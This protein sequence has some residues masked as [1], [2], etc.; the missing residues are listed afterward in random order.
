MKQNPFGAIVSV[1][2]KRRKVV[3]FF[4]IVLV[5]FGVTTYDTMTKSILPEA[6]FPY[7]SVATSLVGASAADMEEMVTIP[8]ENNLKQLKDVKKITSASHNGFA[9]VVIQFN[10]GVDNAIKVQQVQ[11]V[12][13][14]LRSKLPKDL[15]APVVEAYDIAKFPIIAVEIDGDR[16]YPQLKKN[17][18]TLER[19]LKAIPGVTTLE[20]DGLNK[21]YIKVTPNLEA[22][23]TYGLDYSLLSGLLKEHQFNM[24]LG[25]KTLYGM[26]YYF[27]S[28]NKMTSI[29]GLKDI[30]INLTR[31]QQIT[32]GDIAEV[33]MGEVTDQRGSYRLEKGHKQKIVRLFLYKDS[34]ADTVAINR[35]VKEL[36]EAFKAEDLQNTGIRTSMDASVFIQ[37]SINDVINNALGGLLS[38]IAVLFL[39]IHFREAIIAAMVI[40]I[41]MIGAFVLFK[42]FNLTLNIMSIMGL[43]I[44]LGMLVDNAIVVI[45]MI[46]EN[47]TH[48]RH[49]S[50][51]DII[52]KATN[53]VAPAIFSSTVTTVGAFIPLAFLSGGDGALIRA[54]PIATALAMGISFIVSITVTP[55]FAYGLI[56]R[57]DK[58]PSKW[59]MAWHTLLIGIIGAYA[60]SDNWQWTTASY[61][62]GAVFM[63]ATVLKYRLASREGQGLSWYRVL[64]DKVLH[65]R[66]YQGIVLGVMVL[67]LVYA[68][69]LLL[70]NRIPKEAMPKADSK[71]LTG[72]VKLVKGATVKDSVALFET[73]DDH[74]ASRED[75]QTYSVDIG[76]ESLDYAIELK[77][78]RQRKKHSKVILA[79]LTAETSALPDVTGS[80]VVDGDEPGSAPLALKLFHDDIDVLLSDARA[81]EEALA[82]IPGALN[83]SLSFDYGAPTV[84]ITIDKEAASLRDVNPSTILRRIRQLIAHEK[85]MD[86]KVA[87][88]QLSVY[89]RPGDTFDTL[90]ALSGL[91][92]MNR[93]Q[94]QVPLSEVMTYTESRPMDVI[95]H[96][97]G[98]RM[99]TV[100]ASTRQGVTVE[101]VVKAL[102]AKIQEEKI[103]SVGTTYSFGGDYKAMQ[104]AY[105]DLMNKFIIAALLVYVVLL[106]QFN[107]Y[108]QP[109][110]ILLSVPFAI[111]GV[112]I[113]Y[114]M[115]G[116]T[117][118][119]LS[120]LGIVSLV[121][122]A[123]NDA[124][125]LVDYINTLRSNK[126][127]GRIEAI[128]EGCVA[129]FKPIMATSLTTMAG[130]APLALYS[131]DYAQ[132]AY[133]LIFGLIG[134]TVLT[135]LVVPTLLN[136]FESLSLWGQKMKGMKDDVKATI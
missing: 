80:F 21:P 77:D 72:T 32:L 113:G 27:D 25:A 99:L 54:I 75:I 119:T 50:L 67:L 65:S 97:D 20:V 94:T 111:I 47:K 73:I 35:Q 53:A 101:S 79:E 16:P 82:T 117:F 112:A 104:A 63:M 5:F 136:A 71:Y 93:R 133:A 10:Q 58:A 4:L 68:G 74:L 126:G 40:P 86:M 78:K 88:T 124:I 120:F 110:A 100:Q 52:L 129:R 59:Q 92:V 87:G 135:L 106:I 121:G 132:M 115:G 134:S 109:L 48:H 11:T 61:M 2:L 66:Y 116:L 122:I 130:V 91:T 9:L 118:S 85:V 62:A 84:T 60:F 3:Y 76:R 49:L 55:V 57:Q 39:F 89:I 44:A 13:N 1:A 30:P 41:T 23:N 81:V 51:K 69:N 103:L 98:K 102:V 12:V 114:A 36:V 107:T 45:E 8:I 43:I 29:K 14:N 18:A 17:V 22:M 95:R 46:D 90:E 96:E 26:T 37:R 64:M 127:M 34:A 131:E 70:S 123:V 125:V 31:G 7:I 28:D 108:L 15:E 6:K 128:V 38:V 56:A 83:P 19:Q 24:P 33:A 105:K 42:P